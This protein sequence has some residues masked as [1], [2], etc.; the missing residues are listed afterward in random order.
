MQ[1]R[2]YKLD[3]ATVAAM[4]RQYVAPNHAI[5]Y[6]EPLHIVRGK[7]AWLFDNDGNAFLDCVNNVAHVGH[8]NA[9]VRRGRAVAGSTLSTVRSPPV[10][11][12]SNKLL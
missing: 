7:G 3:T 12:T 11:C 10:M 2:P 9:K 1:A 8:S 4:R 6:K 5:M